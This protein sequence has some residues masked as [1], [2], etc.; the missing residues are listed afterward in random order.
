M[1]QTEQIKAGND[2][3]EVSHPSI[4]SLHASFP[5]Q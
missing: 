2:H 3:H 1:K 5:R 4:F